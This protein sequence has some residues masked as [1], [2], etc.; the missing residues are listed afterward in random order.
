MDIS[1]LAQHWSGRNV[2]PRVSW[3]DQQ[4]TPARMPESPAAKITLSI[5]CRAG[6]PSSVPNLRRRMVRLRTHSAPQNMNL[7]AVEANTWD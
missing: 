3:A 5:H 6:P 4:D 2:V 1:D 7:K